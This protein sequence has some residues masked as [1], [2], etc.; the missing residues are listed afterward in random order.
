MSST[1]RKK[2]SSFTKDVAKG[3]AK[4][5]GKLASGAAVGVVTE[6]A[7]IL[8]L[9]LFRP[10]RRWRQRSFLA[11]Q[12]VRSCLYDCFSR[13]VAVVWVRTSPA[14]SEDPPPVSGIEK[15]GLSSCRWLEGPRVLNEGLWRLCAGRAKN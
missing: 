11:E 4:G 2:K 14:T 12:I 9:G 3:T 8:S 5:L 1:R 10:P 15:P 13:P 7:S 6:L